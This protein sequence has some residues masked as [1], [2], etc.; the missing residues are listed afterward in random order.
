MMQKWVL[1]SWCESQMKEKWKTESGNNAREWNGLGEHRRRLDVH[2]CNKWKV[3][4]NTCIASLA[5]RCEGDN[6]KSEYFIG[7]EPAAHQD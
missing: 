6:K 1:V 5:R 3:L 7:A 2:P 4:K